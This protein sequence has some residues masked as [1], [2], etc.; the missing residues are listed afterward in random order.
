[1]KILKIAALLLAA[2]APVAFGCT[3]DVGEAQDEAADALTVADEASAP[4]VW[5]TRRRPR[6]RRT[7]SRLLS[8]APSTRQS[9]SVI[10]SG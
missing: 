8:G 5:R 7:R 3:A 10:V 6:N 4:E 9:A 1:M 2:A